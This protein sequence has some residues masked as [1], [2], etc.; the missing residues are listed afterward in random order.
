LIGLYC[1]ERI[2]IIKTE[3]REGKILRKCKTLVINPGST[4]TKIAVFNNEEVILEKTLRHSS[5][6]I[7]KYERVFD[8]FQFRKQIILDELKG[9]DFDIQTLD[10][11]VGRGGVLKPI[12]GGTYRVNEKMLED[13]KISA[14]GEHASN[15]GAVIANDIA[16]ELNIPAFI[17]DP[18]VVDEMQSLARITGLDGYERESKFHAL[19]QK[20]VARKAAKELGKKYDEVNLVVA[21][22][23]GGISVG[24]H[25]KGRVIDVNNAL[26]GEGAFSP[27]RTGGLPTRA[28]L[29]MCITEKLTE[30]EIKQR[31]A[32]KG[33]LVSYLGIN[34][35]KQVSEMV[36]EGNEKA[37]LIYKA[38]AYQVAKDIAG[39]SAVLKG[40][41][42]AIVIT[43]GVA[44]DKTFVGWISERVQFISQI[45][46]YPGEL[47]L[48]ALREG[49][50]R[51][52]RKEEDIKIYE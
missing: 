8:Q 27:E 1:S 51:V 46:V 23:G 13:I 37:E 6:E 12:L 26:Y 29:E 34:D 20:A 3:R 11:I 40:N 21:H 24:A 7:K 42:D 52:L 32:G 50:L 41:V 30:K 5:E 39:C 4:S 44:Y 45:K 9:Y 43:G 14:R 15:L 16:G 22:L 19:N 25:E 28:V 17:V 10:A 2:L 49:A 35:A 36:K 18:P 47:E 31:L 48:E 38:M 33:G